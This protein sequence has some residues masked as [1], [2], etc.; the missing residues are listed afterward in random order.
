MGLMANFLQQKKKS[1]S[2]SKPGKRTRPKI[3]PRTNAQKINY[4]CEGWK[5]RSM[6]TFDRVKRETRQKILDISSRVKI[7]I[8]TFYY[9]TKQ[10]PNNQKQKT[11]G[12]N[13]GAE[14]LRQKVSTIRPKI[15]GIVDSRRCP[16]ALQRL[17]SKVDETQPKYWGVLNQWKRLDHWKSEIEG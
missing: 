15:H 8:L 10:P 16:V 14:K 5:S 13:R 4:E 11:L 6:L 2:R 12:R 9:L 17:K 7:E 3:A 1:C